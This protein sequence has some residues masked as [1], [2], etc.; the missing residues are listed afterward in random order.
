MRRSNVQKRMET[1]RAAV[2]QASGTAR[3]LPTGRWVRY[4]ETLLLVALSMLLTRAAS[5]QTV[6]TDPLNRD[7][8]VRAAYDRFYILDYA[9]ALERF[10]K[11]AADHP[12]DP[13]ATGYVLDTVLFG[14]LYRLDLLD[15]TLYAHDGFL[16]GKHPVEENRQVTAQITQL[17]DKMIAQA[18]GILSKDSKNVNALYARSWARSMKS[19]YMGLVQHSFIGALHLALQSRNDSDKILQIDPD[20]VDADLVVGVHQYVVGSLGFAFKMMAGIMGDGGSKQKGLALLREAGEHGVLTSVEART[21]LMLFLRREA[22]YGDA[23]SVA[24]SLKNQ[25]PRDFLFWLEEAN[26]LKDSG[27]AKQ[28]IAHYRAALEQAKKP[29][30]FP[31]AHLELAWYGLADTLRGQRAFQESADAFEQVVVQPTVTP[32]LKRRAQLAAGQE[33]DLLQQRDKAT[34]AYKA[35]LNEGNDSQ[36]AADAKKYLRSPFG[37]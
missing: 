31:N 7:P 32:D 34:A 28:A 9:G 10:Q 5:A 29:G 1:V 33:Y 21:A 30:Y 16:S 15:T 24:L 37:H 4:A 14:E 35:V 3:S 6:N 2:M 20:Y 22:K 19:I 26:L 17:S 36:Q 11:I 18:D 13:I 27:D 8:A 25:Y 12:D 23:T